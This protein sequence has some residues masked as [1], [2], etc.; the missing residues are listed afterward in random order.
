MGVLAL[1]PENGLDRS[2]HAPVYIG[3]LFL[4]FFRET[5]GW[6]FAG[7]VVPG[8]LATV[9][10]AAPVTG[11]LVVV[12]AILTYMAALLLGRTLPRTGA[13]FTFFG[14][15][16]FLLLI[17]A[18]SLIRL[19]IEGSLLPAIMARWDLIHSRELY[20]LGLV[21]VPLLANSFWNA[22]FVRAF[23]RVSLVTTLTY[24]IVS[25]LLLPYTNFTL[26]RFQVANESVSLAF[27]ESPHAHIILL[28]GAILGARN[29]VRYGWDYNGILVPALLAVAWY[30]PAKVATT[31]LE[32][33]AVYYTSM[34]LIRRRP[35]SRMMFVGCRRVVLTFSVGFAIKY[36]SGMLLARYWPQVQL[37]DFFGFGYL[38]PSLLANKMWDKG[39]V[40]KV[41]MPTLQ[42]SVL[43]FPI[44]TLIGYGLRAFEPPAALAGVA[45]SVETV[46]SVPWALMLGDT[47]PAPDRSGTTLRLGDPYGVASALA[48]LS[49]EGRVDAAALELAGRG[50]LDLAQ[51]ASRAWTV[52]PPRAPDPHGAGGGPR[53]AVRG[54]IRYG[55]DWLIS[56]EAP[57]VGSPSVPIAFALAERIGARA[58]VLV[59]RHGSVGEE[60]RR[61][62]AGLGAEL[63]MTRVVR[64]LLK[65]ELRAP[66]LG[67]VGELPGGVSTRLF[68]E[69]LGE[70]V[71]LE[72]RAPQQSDAEATNV[73]ELQV[74]TGAAERVAEG[75]L[76]SAPL[77]LW[78]LS[79]DHDLAK[80]L[81]E[82]SFS[83]P[84]EY[85]VPSI[86]ELR[87][88]GSLLLERFQDNAEPSAWQRS[89]ARLLGLEF[90][91]VQP[92]FA[93]HAL[94]EPEGPARRGRPT[95]LQ[96]AAEP[97]A[98]RGVALTL[99][100]PRWELGAVSALV[101]L[102]EAF[103][104]ELLVVNGALV[105]AAPDLS[106]DPRRP[107]GRQSLFQR[108]HEAWLESG[109]RSII[110]R[111]IPDTR[112]STTDAIV[113]FDNEVSG[114]ADAP[115]WAAPLLGRLE[116]AG[117]T[118]GALDG[119]AERAGFEASADPAV[120]YGR[121]FA[122]GRTFVLWLGGNLRRGWGLDA[123]ARVTERRLGAANIPAY[124]GSLEAFA[125]RVARCAAGEDAA[126]PRAELAPSCDRRATFETVSSFVR[127]NNPYYLEAALS[128]GAACGWLSVVSAATQ[129]RWLALPPQAAEPSPTDSAAAW[130]LV[131]LVSGAD[132]GGERTRTPR[133]VSARQFEELIAIATT[134]FEVTAQ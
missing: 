102:R 90:A 130:L 17:A 69:V 96:R 125:S 51:T 28:V 92:P 116:R 2:L 6:G 82:L 100:A 63:G 108:A 27:L 30:Q 47:A 97:G 75:M 34:W 62:A 89:R 38:L 16:R 56:V 11:V 104:A 41:L 91:K 85:R 71:E 128:P 105:N 133:R 95:L 107:Q 132:D 13:W 101:R 40:P 123:P 9:M 4:V 53:L 55:D 5:L 12:E 46:E 110:V 48:R 37:I 124:P 134:P 19:A 80:R 115:S 127:T 26:S 54:S 24:L 73:L 25:E 117:V 61:F 120:A 3:L 1:F 93:G 45:A 20:S 58:I 36:S 76:G 103:R 131:P 98:E 7:L 66:R 22:G 18:A 88:Y 50:R 44:G 87:M 57:A 83:A 42:V 86:R 10:I 113:T 43:A 112:P 119:S 118:L 126:C 52:I 33:L 121:R 8:Y 60:D 114:L 64:L 15:E 109:G 122:P 23:P 129:S 65:P 39:G 74:S 21:L 49:L 79:S 14:R 31:L 94:Y 68:D 106:S 70:A 78:Q 29:N 84:G 111:G 77:A 99:A 81:T 32:A 72:W 35:L 67:A 59:S